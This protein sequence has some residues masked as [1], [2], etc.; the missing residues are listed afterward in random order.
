MWNQHRKSIK[1]KPKRW[2]HLNQT[3][4]DEQVGVITFVP[5]SFSFLICFVVIA[6]LSNL[7]KFVICHE[8]REPRETAMMMTTTTTSTSSIVPSSSSSSINI[9][10]PNSLLFNLS[11]SKSIVEPYTTA[12]LSSDLF[13]NM[14]NNITA[15]TNETLLPVKDIVPNATL[16]TTEASNIDTS[17]SIKSIFTLSESVDNQLNSVVNQ[18]I[19]GNDINN[20]TQAQLDDHLL[21]TGRQ[22]HDAFVRRLL[23]SMSGDAVRNS[24]RYQ[25]VGRI[26]HAD[27]NNP[28]QVGISSRRQTKPSLTPDPHSDLGLPPSI[29]HEFIDAVNPPKFNV[30]HGMPILPNEHDWRSRRKPVNRYKVSSVPRNKN[31]NNDTRS[32]TV[33]SSI[34]VNDDKNVLL[35]KPQSSSSGN[36]TEFSLNNRKVVKKPSAIIITT[37]SPLLRTTTTT[38][39]PT[40]STTVTAPTRTKHINS[41]N[42][43]QHG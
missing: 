31:S 35:A 26:A 43:V 29:A 32:V 18:L 17:E 23:S 22:T 1:L 37:S 20:Q 2:R 7:P 9:N 4:L 27:R 15:T 30:P 36:T 34:S 33:G 6:V 40:T 21:R 42:S 24:N 28:N 3:Q 13:A 14:T 19:Q 11:K 39:M 25:H 10:V 8:Q 16:E 38:T 41:L 12:L 5:S